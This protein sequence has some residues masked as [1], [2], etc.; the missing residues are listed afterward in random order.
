M[1]QFLMGKT[2]LALGRLEPALQA[3]LT[4]VKLDPNHKPTHYQLAQVYARLNDKENSQ[5]HS[6]IFRRLTEK[7]REKI[8]R[9]SATRDRGKTLPR[10][11]T[12]PTYSSVAIRTS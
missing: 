11:D 3:L 4:A 7:E 9:E 1:A 8:A 10:Q 12:Q 6:E 2:L 5:K